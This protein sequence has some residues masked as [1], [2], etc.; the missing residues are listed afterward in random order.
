MNIY[1]YLVLKY[2]ML[3]LARLKLIFGSKDKMAKK[4]QAEGMKI[5][6]II[7][8]MLNKLH[9]QN[10]FSCR[11]VNSDNYEQLISLNLNS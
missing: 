8:N 6:Q 10:T 9:E 2:C 3:Y 5:K 11:F 4:L 1:K 7:K